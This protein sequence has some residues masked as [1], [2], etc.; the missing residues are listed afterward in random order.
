MGETVPASKFP[1][2]VDE[3]IKK[4]RMW[5]IMNI[6][7]QIRDDFIDRNIGKEFHVL[8]EN[9]TVE[10]GITKWK[11]WTQNYIEADQDT[12]DIQSGEIKRNEIVTGILK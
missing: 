10:N 12:F 7:D 11:G 3:K 1:N 6:S 9:V 8:I 4:E 2:Q 5:E